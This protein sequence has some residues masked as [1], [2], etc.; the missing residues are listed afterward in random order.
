MSHSVTNWFNKK[1]ATY[2]GRNSLFFT[3]DLQYCSHENVLGLKL[4]TIEVLSESFSRVKQ[5]DTWTAK[6]SPLNL[7]KSYTIISF[8]APTLTQVTKSPY[9]I[10]NSEYAIILRFAQTCLMGFGCNSAVCLKKVTKTYAWIKCISKFELWK[11]KS[12]YFAKLLVLL[13]H[14]MTSCILI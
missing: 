1:V 6:Y 3:Y 5:I 7:K 4:L 14:D 13:E 2:S 8:S 12:Q 11:F 9:F 10:C